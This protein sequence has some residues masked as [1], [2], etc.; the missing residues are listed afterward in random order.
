MLRARDAAALGAQPVRPDY[1]RIVAAERPGGVLAFLANLQAAMPAMDDFARGDAMLIRGRL[2][3]N[4]GDVCASQDAFAASLAAAPDDQARAIVHETLFAIGRECGAPRP[5][6]LE[7]AAALWEAAGVGWRADLERR[8]VAGDAPPAALADV[9]L[10]ADAPA[11]PG[12][13]T[14]TFGAARLPLTPSTRIGAQA[15]RVS[16]D[17]LGGRLA[18]P[19]RRDP[20][21]DYFEGAIVN[22]IAATGVPEPAMLYGTLVRKIGWHWYAPDEDGRP[23]FLVLNDKVEHYPTTRFLSDDTAVLVDAHGVSALAALALERHVDV[24][25]GCCDYFDK[26][27]AAEYLAVRGIAVVCAADRFLGYSIGSSTAA[28]ILGGGLVR[29]GADGP[30]IASGSV[31]MRVDEPIVVEDTDEPY[32]EQYADTPARYFALLAERSGLGFAVTTVGHRAGLARLLAVARARTAGIVAVRVTSTDDAALVATWLEESDAHRALLFHS[33]PYPPGR[34]LL[35]RYPDRTATPDA[36]PR[37]DSRP[38]VR[39][40]EGRDPARDVVA[41]GAHGLDRLAL[42]VG[43]TPLVTAEPRD[44]RTSLAASHGDQ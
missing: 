20:A 12:T 1:R 11:P 6:D 35:D 29:T 3:P 10:I 38:V 43:E 28:P 40:H 21:I 33:T 24:V 42:R 2:L 16:R 27:L 32:P 13:T 18:A 17:W 5:A 7:Q 15:E 41:D 4:R 9:P 19:W 37:F 34:Q 14:V 26:V 31:A 30:A 8:I 23:R 22:A 25:I 36:A 39:A 44:D